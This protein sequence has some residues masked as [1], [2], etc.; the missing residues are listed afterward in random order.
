[1][2]ATAVPH[3][4]SSVR[5]TEPEQA[6][7]E[8]DEWMYDFDHERLLGYEGN[9][10]LELGH[11][12][13]AARSFEHALSGAPATC[14][15]RRAEISVDLAQARLG[16]GETAEAVRL[17]RE[18]ITVFARRGST[19]GMSRVRRLRDRMTEQRQDVAVRELDDFVRT[20]S[21]PYPGQLVARATVSYDAVQAVGETVYWIE[22]RPSGDVLV[23]WTAADGSQ[24]VLPE[25]F[26]VA[27]YV[28]EYGGGAY[29]AT[30]RDLWFCNADDQRIYRVSDGLDP[31]PVTPIPASPGALRYADLRLLPG[32]GQLICV[33]ER[34]E[35][36]GS[37][38]NELVVLPV[39]GSAEPR[40]IASGDDFYMSPE[41]SPD[42]RRLAWV[43]W[44]A[45]LMPWDGSCLWVADIQ[46]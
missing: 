40:A 6:G 15:R 38:H 44:N 16:E 8:S 1:M 39:D 2:R 45:P 9:C 12:A 18:A 33:R 23:R 35:D 5:R 19:S 3:S 43:S 21:G 42:G 11:Y 14:V 4:P 34:H 22:G 36:D 26:H 20:S 46:L 41:P 7:G 10:L 37:V 17:A 30:E 31:V 27:S 32:S 24:D 13:Q 29:L 28:H 25:G